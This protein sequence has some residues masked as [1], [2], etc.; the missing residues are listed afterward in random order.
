[1]VC[2]AML[3]GHSRHVAT[4]KV[5]YLTCSYSGANSRSVWDSRTLSLKLLRI[6]HSSGEQKYDMYWPDIRPGA[7]E[8]RTWVS[9][10]IARLRSDTERLH[11]NGLHPASTR[12]ARQKPICCCVTRGR[13]WARME[14][15]GPARGGRERRGRP[16]SWR[17]PGTVSLELSENT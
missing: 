8:W 9:L 15:I 7:G 13:E 14:T 2:Y 12:P 1:M 6:T 17:R 16:T 4:C 5:C 3:P 11:L 10:E